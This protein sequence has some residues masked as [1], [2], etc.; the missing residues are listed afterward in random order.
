M[1]GLFEPDF[2]WV[3]DSLAQE[4]LVDDEGGFRRPA[5]DDR[6]VGFADAVLSD[7]EAQL[8]GGLTGFRDEDQAA[9][10]AVKAVNE[11]DGGAVYDFKSQETSQFVPKSVRSSRTG[12]MNQ[13]ICGFVNHQKAVIFV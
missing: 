2:G 12:G 3:N 11:R 5:E 1:N 6:R 8:P 9:G 7:P 13:K 4:R 10:F